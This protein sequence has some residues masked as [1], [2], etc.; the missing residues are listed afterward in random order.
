MT[1]LIIA[2]VLATAAVIL[3]DPPSTPP[4]TNG[5]SV[6]NSPRTA[7][8]VRYYDAFQN[9]AWFVSTNGFERYTNSI[10]P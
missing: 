1:R 4:R 8:F 10:T 7:T 5:V 2:F 9:R 6:T 3:S